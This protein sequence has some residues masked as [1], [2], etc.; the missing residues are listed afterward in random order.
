M[1]V[2]AKQN[3]NGSWTCYGK[4]RGKEYEYTGQSIYDAKT[5]FPAYVSLLTGAKAITVQFMP[6]EPY[7]PLT[8]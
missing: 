7:T 4:Y 6:N 3:E 1:K 2:T 8:H 5:G